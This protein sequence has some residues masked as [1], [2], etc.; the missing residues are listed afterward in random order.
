MKTYQEEKHENEARENAR[1]IYK[2]D[3]CGTGQCGY[4]GGVQIGPFGYYV[5]VDCYDEQEAALREQDAEHLQQQRDRRG[6]R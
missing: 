5:C 3:F 2:V 1:P 4:F 6:P